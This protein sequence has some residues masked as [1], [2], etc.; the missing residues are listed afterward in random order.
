MSIYAQRI[1]QLQE[2]Y[3]ALAL[4]EKQ[5]KLEKERKKFIMSGKYMTLTVN[6]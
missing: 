2:H 3:K 1:A 4:Q 6:I 5:S